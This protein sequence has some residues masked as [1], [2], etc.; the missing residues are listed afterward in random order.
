MSA[1]I[2]IIVII[3]MILS[4]RESE[5]FGLINQDTELSRNNPSAAIAPDVLQTGYTGCGKIDYTRADP[6]Q[7]S[8]Y[9][10]CLNQMKSVAIKQLSG[11]VGAS[12]NS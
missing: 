3:L 2:L 4:I 12:P 1:T 9:Y 11:I 6:E 10:T 5:Q 7:L 8:K